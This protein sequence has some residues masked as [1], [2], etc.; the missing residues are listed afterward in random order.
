VDLHGCLFRSPWALTIRTDSGS[1]WIASCGVNESQLGFILGRQPPSGDNVIARFMNVIGLTL[2]PRCLNRRYVL[3]KA[4]TY[5]SPQISLQTNPS[6]TPCLKSESS[7]I[8]EIV[9]VPQTP[10][11]MQH[12][13]QRKDP[14]LATHIIG[15]GWSLWSRRPSRSRARRHLRLRTSS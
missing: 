11:P 13:Y 14:P 5:H 8:I 12:L 3:L 15:M 4:Q 10:I 7:N 9:I 6:E 2:R 1:A